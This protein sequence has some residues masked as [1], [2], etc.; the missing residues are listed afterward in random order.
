M[1]SRATFFYLV[2]ILLLA[3]APFG[4]QWLD[5]DKDGFT[6]NKGDCNEEDPTINPKAVEVCDGQ[7]NDCDGEID[8]DSA[9][10]A[11]TWYEDQDGDSY[12]GQ[13]PIRSRSACNRPEGYS[14]NHQDCN[15]S[16]PQIHPR[17]EEIWYDG[18]DQNC[19]GQ[20]DFDQDGD[21]Y[22]SDKHGG[23]DCNDRARKVHPC[24]PEFID[25]YSDNNCDGVHNYVV[26]L[27]LGRGPECMQS[28]DE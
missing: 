24:A 27:N 21:G 7:D 26:R 17:A 4:A 15:D 19:D 13:H 12:G 23:D 10:G 22:R 16:D 3:M 1:I 18:I 14:R 28:S 2:P 6:Q 25:N 9:A 20:D 8:E 11:P 5:R